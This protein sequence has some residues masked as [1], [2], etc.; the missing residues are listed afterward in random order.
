MQMMQ[1]MTRTAIH[2]LKVLAAVGAALLVWGLV[3]AYASSPAWAAN[4]TVNSAADTVADDGDCTLREAIT[5]TNTD[6]ASGGCVAGSGADRITFALH[7][8]STIS[9]NSELLIADN[10]QI[11]GPGA[12]S[13][14][15][16]GNNTSRIFF[17]NPGAPGATSGPPA[18]S[19]SVAISNLTIANG[20]A[21]GGNG[22]ARFAAGGSGGAA[23]MGGAIFVNNGSLTTSGVTFSGNQAQGGNASGGGGGFFS[24]SGGAG[25]GGDSPAQTF[26]GGVGGG[27]G[28][29][30]GNGGAGGNDG[31]R[32]TNGGNGGPG[33]D[34]AGGGGGGQGGNCPRDDDDANLCV[35]P[36]GHGGN[37]GAGGFGGGGG[38][39]GAGGDG[40]FQSGPIGS[41]AGGDGGAGGFGGGGGGGGAGSGVGG[42]GGSFG[43]AGGTFGT[44]GTVFGGGGA[45]LGG[46]IFIRAGSL[47]LA[48]DSSFTNNTASGG[49][50]ANNGK[51]KGGAIFILS[52]ATVTT[53][54]D[55]VTFSGNSATDAAGSGTDTN[56]TY[57]GSVP[58]CDHT[59]P[60][61][62]IE[63]ASGQAD[64]TCTS[65]IHF[66]AVFD[67]PVSGFEGS[68]VTLS[69]TAGATTAVVTEAAPNDGTTYDVAV[70]G[71]R[72]DGPVIAS[73]PANVVQDAAQ[74]GNTA[75]TSDEDNT[76]TF[77]TNCPPTA[78]DDS[79]SINEDTPLSVEKPGVLGN[80]KDPD[81]GD[82]LG[83]V[84]VSGPSHA[85][86][87]SFTLNQDGS[88]S[89]TPNANYNGPDSFTYTVSDGHGGTDTA[90]VD[91]TVTSV[92][93]APDALNDTAV[94]DED[95]A[96]LIDVRANDADVESDA[97]S[98]SGVT[99]PAHG[100]AVVDNGKINYT[101][102][103]DYNGSD[104][105]TYT[106]SDGHGGTDTATVNVTV[107]PVN[108]APTVAVAAGGAC[109]T[110][111]RSGTINLTV[112]DPD[113]QTQTGSLKLSA[114][115]TTNTNLVPTSNVTFGGS[116][117]SRTL[118]A[119]AL[120]GK[121]GTAVLTVT[122]TDEQQVK[123]APLT[124]NV[125][126]GGNGN[127]TLVGDANSDILLGQ[128]GDDTL[129]GMGGNDL[130]C[131]ARGNDRLTG[132]LGADR[133]EGGSGN[134][135]ATD[136]SAGDSKD[137]TIENF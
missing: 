41:G 104:S 78:V 89:Y 76:V 116:G 30:G 62:S 15:I 17:V 92:N 13:L 93:D 132:G 75:S 81:S 133:F 91:I 31:R 103:K 29:L 53:V 26:D 8:P 65:P 56:D 59:P 126:V 137:G 109:G 63:R 64:T 87:D 11:S 70:S 79:Y 111:D 18:T 38:G 99:D 123:G 95:K 52:P 128:N 48:D 96:V 22:G 16:S 77:D 101:P 114:T 39:G 127:N 86:T 83:A 28:A 43:G 90:T 50:G 118:T 5:S 113:G 14:T 71:M 120:S 69:G 100:T 2:P 112:N 115:D 58:V 94:I 102:A 136:F 98:I 85:A 7:Y 42:A 35:G 33:G 117:A 73:V 84:L 97:L 110:N 129:R 119:A 80:D 49:T 124:V 1:M 106:V 27:G 134:D 44:S 24:G 20:L 60:S 36:A 40:D 45:G 67:E 121:T 82:T 10:L 34:G 57:G 108:D 6:T 72:S 131:G 19:L 74:N 37:G 135:T 46:A 54:S 21:K 55:C 47:T 66:T 105:F 122:V 9:L 32:G 4:I 12:T 3:L 130:L 51:G 88:F 125:R 107:N 61:V 68:D 23:G 25:V